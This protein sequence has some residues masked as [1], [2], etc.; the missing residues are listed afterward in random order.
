MPSCNSAASQRP[1]CARRRHPKGGESL[2]DA[3]HLARWTYTL[4][5][6]D[7]AGRLCTVPVS[8]EAVMI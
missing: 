1:W 3:L 2:G 8:R 4:Y 6:D 5:T 7:R